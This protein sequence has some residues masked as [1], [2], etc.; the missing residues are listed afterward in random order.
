MSRL[1]ILQSKFQRTILG[2]EDMLEKEIVATERLSVD[3]RIA[4]YAEAY[5][6]RLT[7]CLRENYSALY[8]LLGDE[9]FDALCRLYIDAHPPHHYSIRWYGDRFAEFARHTAP[10][11]GHPYVSELAEFEWKLMEAFDA[12][13]A[14]PVVLDE[15]AQ[16]APS[17]WPG[18][19]LEFQPCLQRVELT[20]NVAAIRNAVD[21]GR[22]ID[23]PQRG[24]RPAAWLI[25]RKRLTQYFRSLDDTEAWALDR[26]R[27]RATFG[28]L[29]EGLCEWMPDREIAT[30]A[31]GLLKQWIGDG[32]VT[33][34]Q[35]D[36]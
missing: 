1:H 3:R 22:T 30:Y 34:I 12:R 33:K 9:Q 20:W 18:L 23:S 24:D 25:W 31:A 29:C 7:E 32:L 21:E 10:Y 14:R 27:D 28:E 15:L 16:L 11:S 26:A 5:R 2:A 13:D 6:L 4:I 8:T 35:T 36:P 17:Q 19:R